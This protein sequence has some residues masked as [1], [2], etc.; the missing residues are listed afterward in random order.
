MNLFDI[1]A[2]ATPTAHTNQNQAAGMRKVELD[3][4]VPVGSVN[5][6]FAESIFTEVDVFRRAVKITTQHVP[7]NHMCEF[8]IKTMF[9]KMETVGAIAFDGAECRIRGRRIV[10]QSACKPD[11][12]FSG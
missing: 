7:Q 11:M 5:R 10:R 4:S 8:I 6:R 9:R 2:D 1:D 3:S 12:N